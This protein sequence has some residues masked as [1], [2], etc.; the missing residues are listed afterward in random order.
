MKKK[1]R[2]QA[3]VQLRTR[4]AQSSKEMRYHRLRHAVRPC[5][6]STFKNIHLSLLVGVIS[7]KLSAII[8]TTQR[9]TR[10][11]LSRNGSRGGGSVIF[12]IKNAIDHLSV[13]TELVNQLLCMTRWRRNWRTQ[14]RSFISGIYKMNLQGQGRENDIPTASSTFESLFRCASDIPGYRISRAMYE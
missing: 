14:I 13:C 7:L 10:A 4:L 3:P 5:F 11:W 6:P 8:H 9:L 1:L 2:A 12:K